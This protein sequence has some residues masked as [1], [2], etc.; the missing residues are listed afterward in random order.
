MDRCKNCKFYIG[1]IKASIFVRNCSG[2]EV[3]VSCSQFRCRDL[4]DSKLFLYTPNDPIIESSSG[5]VMA[6][7]NFVYPQLKEH[8]DAAQILGTFVDD[9]GVT[10]EKVNKWS[11]VFDFTKQEDG[12]PNYSLIEKDD[13][14]IIEAIEVNPD[15]EQYAGGD[16]VF[17]YP[18]EYGGT[19]EN[20]H[21]KVKDSLMA[22]DITTG[23][24]EAQR[25]F[26][27]K[28]KQQ[29]ESEE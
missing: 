3:T 4:V 5:L 21:Q 18:K 22:F 23:A 12:T 27:E 28:Q 26:D 1:P 25:Q 9:D 13:F 29:R 10:Q 17:D 16:F 15:L 24:A 2:C 20:E 19:L 6:P 8:A 11:Q 7:Y 14:K